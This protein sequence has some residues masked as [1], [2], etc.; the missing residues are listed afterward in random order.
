MSE[1]V[2]DRG[3]LD[4]AEK[5]GREFFVT[6]ADASITFEAAE[7]VF[8][9]VPVAVVAAMVGDGVTARAFR[10]NTKAGA[11]TSQSDAKGVGI[12]AFVADGAMAAQGAE[13]RIDRVQVVAL[14]GGQTKRDGSPTTLN[15]GREL[16][17]DATLGATNRLAG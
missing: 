11:L 14:A 8:D 3:E 15:D 10:R 12:E 7:E 1:P 9:F 5:R 13:Q 17:V 16:G 4:E 2:E 6:G